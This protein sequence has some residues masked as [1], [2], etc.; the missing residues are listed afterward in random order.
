VLAGLY[1]YEGNRGEVIRSS[2]G[3]ASFETVLETSVPVNA[4]AIHPSN[5]QLMFAGT[6]SFYAPVAPGGL[7]ISTDGG[8]TWNP[9]S[10][11]NVVVNSV[12]LSSAE[13]DLIYAGCGGSDCAY[14]GIF[15][16]TDRGATW[17]KTVSG[18]PVEYAITSLQIDPF[19]S[20]VVYAASFY[21][22]IFATLDQGNYWTL[23]GLSDYLVYDVVQLGSTAGLLSVQTRA[24]Q[25]PIIPEATI[26]AGTTSGLY[27]YSG[28]GSGLLNGVITAEDTGQMLDA[29]Q[30]SS[31]CGST[32]ISA[33]GYYLLLMPSGTHTVD[34]SADGYHTA[35][36]TNVQIQ[37][38][39]SIARDIALEPRRDNSS[40]PAAA[41]LKN[42]PGKIYLPVLRKFRDSVLNTSPE[43]KKLIALYYAV[44]PALIPVLEKRHDLR[45][46][47]LSLLERCMPV[48]ES[49]LSG[50]TPA[51]S[52]T[53]NGDVSAFLSELENA[54]PLNMRA[55]F[56]QLNHLLRSPEALKFLQLR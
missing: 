21:G 15:K 35:T 9:T 27:Q 4:V 26:V 48:I 31:S 40:C 28:A 56:A 36:L 5:P 47:C 41:L 49:A 17:S 22:G 23:I 24:A 16:S 6:G 42:T 51:L 34:I 12:A 2:D 11:Q 52:G 18:L 32:C 30:V 44:G 46:R 53:L 19:C 20:D 45:A 7:F 37:A 3:G 10:L 13:P 38:G 14:A 54:A 25:K 43:G 55:T 1:F 50:E 29:A 39:E 8:A 33:E